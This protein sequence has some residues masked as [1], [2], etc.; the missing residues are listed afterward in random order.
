MTIAIYTILNRSICN[1][2]NKETVDLRKEHFDG[3]EVCYDTFILFKPHQCVYRGYLSLMAC[4][5]C[6]IFK[7]IFEAF[8]KTVMEHHNCANSNCS[9]CELSES[10]SWD[11][12]QTECCEY[13]HSSY[14]DKYSSIPAL[15][16]ACRQCSDCKETVYDRILDDGDLKINDDH[17]ISYKHLHKREESTKGGKSRYKKEEK[18]AS[19][20]WWT[21]RNRLLDAVNGYIPHLHNFKVQCYSR[22]EIAESLRDDELFSSLDFG[23][24]IYLSG[25]IHLNSR[26]ASE[27]QI[28][29]IYE[30]DRIQIPGPPVRNLTR[31]EDQ[32]L[33]ADVERPWFFLSDQSKKGSCSAL[34]FF[35]RYLSQRKEQ[36]EREHGGTKLRVLYIFGDRCSG[37][38]WGADWFGH[39]TEIGKKHGVL[40]IS[41]TLPGGHNKWLHDAYINVGKGNSRRALRGGHIVVKDGENVVEVLCK[42]LQDEYGVSKDFTKQYTYVYVNAEDVPPRYSNI[43]TLKIGSDGIT[44]FHAAKVEVDGTLWFRY[45]LCVCDDCRSGSLDECLFDDRCGEWIQCTNIQHKKPRQYIP[46]KTQHSNSNTINSL[47]QIPQSDDKWKGS[48]HARL[49]VPKLKKALKLKGVS[50]ISSYRKR[51]LVLEMM[52]FDGDEKE[53]ENSSAMPPA[54]EP[55]S[56]KPRVDYMGVPEQ[57]RKPQYEWLWDPTNELQPSGRQT[58]IKYILG[59]YMRDDV[60]SEDFFLSQ[61][62]DVKTVIR[63]KYRDRTWGK[64]KIR[65]RHKQCQ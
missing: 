15:K 60:E 16:C 53:K 63:L 59:K 10:D 33:W 11:L 51:E 50:G 36:Y 26:C 37:D 31:N 57:L 49:T 18:T 6:V 47:P 5:N 32:S 3:K 41:A 8:N 21:F 29:V 55:P 17:L 35:D 52:K 14:F 30:R 2:W 1:I 56:K 43:K 39:L 19:D 23:E 24:N 25:A 44:K 45:L 9:L 65:R 58:I 42:Y 34:I 38:T 54:L 4:D 46:K 61:V 13:T 28:F 22:R 27:A 62:G 12:L 40:L 20:Q 48:I 64:V 7:W